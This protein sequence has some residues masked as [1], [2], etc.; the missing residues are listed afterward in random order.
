[1]LIYDDAILHIFFLSHTFL[2]PCSGRKPNT[3]KP[4][5]TEFVFV[6][7]RL[8]TL[9]SLGPL[10][11]LPTLPFELHAHCSLLV[12]KCSAW[13]PFS[14]EHSTLA[15]DKQGYNRE[16]KIGEKGG[17][18]FVCPSKKKEECMLLFGGG[19]QAGLDLILPK[20]Q[21]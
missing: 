16:Y 10:F 6:R 7:M 8:K 19:Q 18:G 4:T 3:F 5:Q 20:F 11:F 2:L 14:F 1:M 13:F 21:K 15:F 9:S 12:S 17:K